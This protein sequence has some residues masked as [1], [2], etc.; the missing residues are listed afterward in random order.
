MCLTQ[1]KLFIYGSREQSQK[2]C[3]PKT[4]NQDDSKP[5]DSEEGMTP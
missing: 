2:F 3:S 4:E 1:I 5:T